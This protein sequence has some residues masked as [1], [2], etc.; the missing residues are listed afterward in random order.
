MNL[1]FT[2]MTDVPWLSMMLGALL[3]F[4][5][6]L[7]PRGAAPASRLSAGSAPPRPRLLLLSGAIL[8][9]AAL[10]RQFA[11][12]T[13]PAFV[14]VL[15]L[16]ARRRHGDRWLWPT[17]RGAVVFGLPVATLFL[18]FHYW[19]T[20]VHGATQA[21]RDTVE[22]IMEVRLW[23]TIFH[24]FEV[25]HYAGLWLLPLGF[26]LLVSRARGARVPRAPAM[27]ALSILG[28]FAVARPL[29]D[30]AWRVALDQPSNLEHALMPYFGNIFYLVGL[31][32][33]TTSEIYHLDAPPPHT[34]LWLGVL[35]TV[36]STVGFAASTGLLVTC[37][38]RLGRAFASPRPVSLG[39]PAGV[40]QS[41]PEEADA[42]RGLLR[43]LLASCAG[44][45]LLFQLGTSTF[46]FDR[47]VLPLLPIVF[48]LG[49]D[50]AP[51]DLARSPAII[52]S[53]AA[54]GIF[55]VALNHEYLSWNGARDRAIR[56]LVARG[57]PAE[58]I[59]GGF[60]H[61]GPLH[62]EAF[63]KRTG[64]LV[65]S[66]AVFWMEDAPW[67]ISFWPSRD[68]DCTTVD[69]HPYWTWPG[70]GDRA[71]YTIRCGGPASVSGSGGR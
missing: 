31:G 21:N 51:P 47:Y 28:G 41:P 59:D 66:S 20:N 2:Y 57:V 64:K 34:G 3:C 53:L 56:A 39:S 10:T 13:A 68:P 70:G 25:M 33:P 49:L 18:P 8:G 24:A 60:E 43:A 63:F 45:Y 12:V 67:R 14:L 11:V 35:L 17:V 42:S 30:G 44:A 27:R 22:R 5:H 71:V 23:K 50:A 29:F 37:R 62:F 55:S 6:A 15:W 9:V 65:S 16:D 52:A 48:L 7:H 32:P 4:A 61:N 46:V 69:R 58:D 38:E 36:A 54:I 26:A 40:P 1:A 19:Y